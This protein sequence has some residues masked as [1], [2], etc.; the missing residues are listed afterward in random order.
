LFK[1]VQKI[2]SNIRVEFEF[3]HFN[4]FKVALKPLLFLADRVQLELVLRLRVDIQASVLLYEGFRSSQR[5]EIPVL[6]VEA[7]A[8]HIIKV[9]NVNYNLRFKNSLNE[10]NKSACVALKK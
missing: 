6:G 8:R 1:V 7:L 3:G 5:L 4:S 2:H 10:K 9:F